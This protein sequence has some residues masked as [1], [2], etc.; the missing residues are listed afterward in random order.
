MSRIIVDGL[1]LLQGSQT[2]EGTRKVLVGGCFDVIHFG[3]VSF[4]RAAKK[5][6]DM[7]VVALENDQFIRDH[8]KREPFHTHQQRA[9]MLSELR[10]VDA[11]IML[12]DMKGAGEYQKLVECIRPSVIAVTT[13]DT[14][15]SNKQLF[16]D[17][18]GARLIEACGPIVGLSSSTLLHYDHLLYD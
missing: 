4:L 5:T 10:T 13:G 18:I 11:V 17:K 8:K 1:A 7:L 9:E 15:L 12:P 3:H 2:L 14:Q 6:G 16:A